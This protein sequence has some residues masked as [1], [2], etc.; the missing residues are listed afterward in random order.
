MP[1]KRV[2]DLPTPTDPVA[3]AKST[4]N[5]PLG[6]RIFQLILEAS[7]SAS[8]DIVDIL[9]L[10]ELD[11]EGQTQQ[12]FDLTDQ[13]K[14]HSLFGAEYDFL[15]DAADV[16]RFPIMLSQ[17][18]LETIVGRNNTA[19]GTANIRSFQAKASVKPALTGVEL[20]GQYVF[21]EGTVQDDQGNLA[22]A[23]L[24]NILTIRSLN[25]VVSATGIRTVD[26]IP[27]DAARPFYGI[28]AMSDEISNVEVKADN[29]RVVEYTKNQLDFLHTVYG[30]TPQSDVFAVLWPF[31]E[32][33]SSLLP[34]RK[35][36]GRVVQDFRLDFT[37]TGTT[38][39]TLYYWTYGPRF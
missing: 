2:L 1:L 27:I 5:I 3:G 33:L 30:L 8:N 16:S 17:R 20:S 13:N 6:P 11:I 25:V 24:G 23:P 4:Y 22:P 36:G 26:N 35:R 12:S 39:F 31:D 28:F 29:Q 21:D 37:M 18:W 15:T 38:D 10:I 14:I 9:G 19:W 34:M 7:D 32:E